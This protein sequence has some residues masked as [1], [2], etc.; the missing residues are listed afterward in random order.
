MPLKATLWLLRAMT[1]GARVAITASQML[2][3][4]TSLLLSHRQSPLGMALPLN[5]CGTDTVE[6]LVPSGQPAKP[7]SHQYRGSL[8][9]C[10][11]GQ[12]EQPNKCAG[13][14]HKPEA[15]RY[16]TCTRGAPCLNAYAHE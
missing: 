8:Q 13:D 2:S 12:H 4:G 15:K 10:Q 5:I 11:D 7:H 14:L 9:E 1:T 3:L 6:G 16:M